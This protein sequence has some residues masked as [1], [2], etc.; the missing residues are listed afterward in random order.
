MP[1]AYFA[2]CL[3]LKEDTEENCGEVSAYL[4]PVCKMVQPVDTRL[5]AGVMDY[6]KLPF[7]LRVMMKTMKSPKGDFRNWETI[8]AWAGQVHDRLV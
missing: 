1:L 8:R 3:T 5:F 4:D 7:I 6:A 2:V